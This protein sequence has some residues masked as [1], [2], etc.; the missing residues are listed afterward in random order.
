M[1]SKDSDIES[2]VFPK[3]ELNGYGINFNDSTE[4]L[5]DFCRASLQ[6]VLNMDTD[7]GSHCQCKCHPRKSTEGLEGNDYDDDDDVD[8]D[9]Y[10]SADDRSRSKS[11][12]IGIMQELQKISAKLKE[13]NHVLAEKKKD[14]LRRE[15][16]LSVSQKNF[17]TIVELE[18]KRKMEGIEKSFKQEL[19]KSL[20]HL[21]EKIKENKRLRENFETLKSANEVLRSEVESLTN[22]R[23]KCD[24]QINSLQAR[25]TNLQRL[26]EQNQK[27][28][29]PSLAIDV[30]QETTSSKTA[31]SSTEK[32]HKR[33]LKA[34]KVLQC[35]GDLLPSLLTWLVDMQLAAPLRNSVA[36]LPHQ[37]N[38]QESSIIRKP[39]SVSERCLKVIPALVEFLREYPSFSGSVSLPCLQFVYWAIKN[40]EDSHNQSKSGLSSTLRRLGE[41]LYH[42]RASTTARITE[43]DILIEQKDAL[44]PLPN[45]NKEGLFFKSSDCHVR[46]LCA[47]IVLK[48]VSQVDFL[49]NVLDDLKNELKSDRGKELFLFYQGTPVVLQYLKPIHK[50]LVNNAIDVFLP[51]SMESPHLNQFLTS[52]SNETW[53]RTVAVVLRAV[54]M[55]DK[56]FE[57]LS[58]ILQKLSKIRHNKKLFDVYSITA[59][60]QELSRSTSTCSSN[61]QDYSF[62]ELNLRSILFNLNCVGSSNVSTT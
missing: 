22:E 32:P 60:I 51:L 12:V 26:H 48:T 4:S 37:L 17:Q 2:A 15:Q 62:L 27:Q 8:N 34:S 20:I 14:L 56:I 39:R 40:L 36:H 54:N 53:F 21:K 9:N 42:S 49:A 58:I 57:K 28:I 3:Q 33:S 30:K 7:T 11:N 46:L 29:V 16:L 23:T 5:Y 55:D 45:T 24:K 41:E 52:C 1:A 19:E 47:L 59:L 6:S 38:A 44:P 50:T 18:I 13:E 61:Q 35:I 43:E 25:L 10:D 31:K